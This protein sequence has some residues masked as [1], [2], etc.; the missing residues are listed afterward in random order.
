MCFSTLFQSY[1]FSI[2][3]LQT[4][5][6]LLHNSGLFNNVSIHS[7][8]SCISNLQ[9]RST[10]SFYSCLDVVVFSQNQWLKAGHDFES[11]CLN[12]S[13]LEGIMNMS[14]STG[15]SILYSSLSLQLSVVWTV[16]LYPASTCFFAI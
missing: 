10:L 4:F 2:S 16:M 13:Y 9:T 7:A 12:D 6:K 1:L 3:S 5:P 11:A 15:V 14:Q 8:R